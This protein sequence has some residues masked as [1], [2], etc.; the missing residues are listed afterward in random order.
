MKSEYPHH[1]RSTLLSGVLTSFEDSHAG[2]PWKAAEFL[3]L[4]RPRSRCPITNLSRTT[5]EE[6][7]KSGA[8]RAKKLR[9][10]GRTRAITLIPLEALVEWANSLP[11][12]STDC[13]DSCFDGAL[14]QRTGSAKDH[15][16]LEHSEKEAER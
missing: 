15:R 13:R 9:R 12:A 3:R 1:Q 5:I 2:S 8:I 14:D 10:P 4:P 16:S 6:L 7:I 11:D